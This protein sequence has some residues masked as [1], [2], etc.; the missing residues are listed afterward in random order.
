MKKKVLFLVNHDIVIYNFRLELVERL[1][2]EGNDVVISSP[3]GERIDDLVELGCEYYPINIARHGVNPITDIVLFKEYK[4]LISKVMPDIV[5]SYTVKP[6]IYGGMACAALNVPYVVNITGLGTALEQDGILQTILIML[7]RY[8]FRKVQRVFCQ[9]RENLAFF[10]KHK[11]AATKLALLP[12][13][14]VNL[15]RFNVLPYPN[16]N[17]IEFAFI[18]RIMKE[19]G[20]DQ[21]LEAAGIVRTKHPNAIFHVCGFCEQEYQKTLDDMTKQGT[22]IYHGM[23]R[24]VRVILSR[25]HCTVLPSFHEGM[26]NVL[27]ESAATGRPVIAS[28]VP[29]CKET[30]DEGISGLGFE[31][32]NTEDLVRA[33][34]G[35]I[36]L[37]HQQKAAMGIAGRHK[38]ERE[39]DRS[40]IVNRYLNEVSHI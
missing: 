36:D 8:A 15:D 12:G 27:L 3:Y 14:G 32:R 29:G 19:K 40:I 5:F 31:V 2:E 37:P 18:S 22:I 1:L 35:F 34:D 7:Y 39:F 33:I 21:Y 16:N 25:T 30:F 38:M 26:A 28:R 20:I 4:R 10:R 23:L 9:N 17:T 6:N 24:N 13:S 11:L